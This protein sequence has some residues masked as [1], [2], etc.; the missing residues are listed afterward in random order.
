MDIHQPELVTLENLGN[1]AIP[2]MFQ[3]ALNRVLKNIGDVNTEWKAK[4]SITIET[5]FAPFDDRSGADIS[6]AVNV[7]LAQS[8]RASTRMFMAYRGEDVR[9]YPQHPNQL[10]MF[11]SEGRGEHA[12]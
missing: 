3:A 9:A 6:L 10:L 2:E 7:K 4:R 5:G 1:G 8:R 11:G 12:R